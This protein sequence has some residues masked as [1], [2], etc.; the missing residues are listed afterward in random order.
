MIVK[1]VAVAARWCAREAARVFA[2]S[3]RVV[4]SHQEAQSNLPN[5]LRVLF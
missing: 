5:V 2:Y 4:I 3:N 1:H